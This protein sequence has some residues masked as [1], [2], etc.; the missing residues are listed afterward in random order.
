MNL[1]TNSQYG[2]GLLSIGFNQDQ[3]NFSK[4]YPWFEGNVNSVV[5]YYYMVHLELLQLILKY[6]RL[7]CV[8]N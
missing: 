4:I 2:N 8:C 5:L 3:G 7:F 6:F 1:R